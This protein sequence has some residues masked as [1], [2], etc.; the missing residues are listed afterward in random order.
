MLPLSMR[1]LH[2]EKCSFTA[3]VG[4]L[5]SLLSYQYT[6]LTERPYG[7]MK[8]DHH[9]KKKNTHNNQILVTLTF[10]I[11]KDSI[12]THKKQKTY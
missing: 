5:S 10:L 11:A 3:R 4:M 1:D 6:V 12:Y 8:N 9:H 2:Q 7:S